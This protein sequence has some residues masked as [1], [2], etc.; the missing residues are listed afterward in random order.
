WLAAPGHLS[1]HTTSRGMRDETTG[2]WFVEGES[3]QEWRDDPHSFLW[4]FGIPG[5]GKTIL[6][7][8][9]VDALS[10]HCRSDHS[11]ALAFFYF[12]F[13]NKDTLPNAVLRSLIEQLS[14]QCASTPP[15]LE[16]LFS[17]NKQARQAPG[18]EDLMSTLKTI[19]SS[20]QAVYIVFDALDEC[21]QRSGFLEVLGE[22]HDWELDT[23]HL[24]ATSRDERDIAKALSGLVSHEVSMDE[25]RFRWVVCQMDALQK[26][27]TPAALEKALIRLPRTLY[28]TYDRILAGIDEDDRRDALSL[29]QW[30]AFSV[31]T[32][33]MDEAVEVLATDPDARE[34]PLFDERRRLLDPSSIVTICSSLVTI[35]PPEGSNTESS[36]GHHDDSV[37][38]TD[39]RLAHFSVREYLI[40]EHLRSST[41]TLSYYWFNEKIAHVFIAKTCL[42]YLLQFN[43]DNGVNRNTARSYPLSHY[44]AVHWMGHALWD[45]AGGSADLHGLTMTLLEPMS[46]AYV[47]WMWIYNNHGLVVKPGIVPLYIAAATGLDR[48]CQALLD[49]GSDVNAPG[50]YYGT[51]LQVAASQGHDTT[52]QLL[53][54]MGAD[55]NSQGGFYGNALQA[56]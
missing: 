21:P 28:E 9:I 18:Q 15:S 48:A 19:I 25:T 54:E 20:F 55:V 16:S 39:I 52:V 50:G 34:G 6:C 31:G 24:L 30:L 36:I 32:L 12:D 47:N 51:P 2:S 10:T 5:A 35:T 56:A 27:R 3:F 1:K 37:L 17:K 22:V 8:T 26:C 33:S 4:L 29:L 43:Q 38:I 49:K 46:A 7:S 40:S 23:L 41:T 11:R 14:S 42:A 13:N 45:A 44:A 53:L